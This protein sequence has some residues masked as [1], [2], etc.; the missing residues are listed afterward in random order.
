[1]V[2]R[3]SLRSPGARGSSAGGVTDL[4]DEKLALLRVLWE[5]GVEG[6]AG[7]AFERR[8][9]ADA[10]FAVGDTSAGV[11]VSLRR[12]R[13]RVCASSSLDR[14]RFADAVLEDFAQVGGPDL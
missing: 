7:A 2:V 8:G 13:L 4:D 1:M 3:P 14:A 10:R 6:P 9:S 11:G 12:R 5:E